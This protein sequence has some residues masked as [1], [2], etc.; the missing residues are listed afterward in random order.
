MC[1]RVLL[2]AAAAA[3]VS[4]VLEQWVVLQR[5]W[6]YLEPIFSR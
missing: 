6:M 2:P 3:Q 1:V 4:E 5:V